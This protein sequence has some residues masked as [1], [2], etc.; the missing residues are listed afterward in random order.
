MIATQ[1]RANYLRVPRVCVAHDQVKLALRRLV[2]QASPLKTFEDLAQDI[3]VSLTQV[4]LIV[5]SIVSFSQRLHAGV[6]TSTALSGLVWLVL[7]P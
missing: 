7:S 3:N 1:A 6:A 5:D 2:E 4:G